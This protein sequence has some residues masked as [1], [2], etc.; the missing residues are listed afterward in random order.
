MGRVK[1]RKPLLMSLV[2]GLSALGMAYAALNLFIP[3]K[4]VAADAIMSSLDGRPVPISQFHGKPTV[5]NLW[6]TWCPPCRREMP[7]FQDGQKSNPD[8]HFVFANQGEAVA[9]V[10][11]Y[12]SQENLSLDNVLLD[13]QGS[14]G[15]DINSRGLPT[16]LFLD[17]SGRLVDIRLGELSPAT[18]QDRINA[19]RSTATLIRSPKE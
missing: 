19:L 5:I 17:G 4:P 18:L 3:K 2:A 13:E 6:A 14:L 16:T 1:L 8:I 10:D 7:A 12:L 11:A 15:H 9:I